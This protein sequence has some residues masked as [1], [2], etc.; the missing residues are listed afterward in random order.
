M[1][2]QYLIVD[3]NSNYKE[4]MDYK[5]LK[6]LLIDT[7]QNDLLMNC[8][9][10]DISK[11]CSDILSKLAKEDFTCVSYITGHLLSYCYKTID[12]LELQR[13]L[14]DCKN[15]FTNESTIPT[16]FDVVL[17]IINKGEKK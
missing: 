1:I 2:K 16:V 13:D 9:E 6:N 4:L 14:E 7:V 5:G 17:D 3:L 11:D 8:S 10:Y 15:Y 12:L